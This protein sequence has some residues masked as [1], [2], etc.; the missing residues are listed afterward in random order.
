[1]E[2][3]EDRSMLSVFTVTNLND[4]GPDSLRQAVADAN[5]QAG[6]DEIRFAVA[7]T[8]ALS[9]GQITITDDLKIDGRSRITIS[10]NEAS[11]V[12]EILDADLTDADTVDVEIKRLSIIDGL[13]AG[14][15]FFESGGGGIRNIG[16]N[17]NLSH[18]TMRDNQAVASLASGGVA[19]AG[20]IDS[21]F[22]G[23][24]EIRHSRFIGNS[25][26][27]AL[28]TA[29]GAI[30]VEGKLT[31]SHSEFTDN[32]A[33]TLLGAGT[34]L[35]AFQGVAAGGAISIGSGSEA[36]I[37]YT[38]FS[39]NVARSGDGIV[40]PG[41]FFNGNAGDAVGGA[42]AVT[43]VSLVVPNAPSTLSVEHSLFRDNLAIGGDAVA[44]GEGGVADG[45]AVANLFFTSVSVEHS[46]FLGNEA[47][48]GA[49]GD[50][51]AGQ[52]GGIGGGALGGALSNAAGALAVE[53]SS[54]HGNVSRGGDGGN[55][56]ADA[57]G[58]QGQIGQGGAVS[59]H[60]H[61]LAPGVPPTTSI[62]G[63]L[64]TKNLAEGGSGG[65][66]SGS[67][68]G[69]TGGRGV[70][71]AIAGLGGPLTVEH[72]SI[73]FNTA[74]GGVG[75]TGGT[76]GVGGNGGN[77]LGGGLFSVFGGTISVTSSLVS[78]NRAIG[79]DG[80]AGASGG[81]GHGGGLWNGA[82]ATLSIARSLVFLNRA[83]GG[84]GGE[85]G[86]DAPGVGGG[87]Y[88]LGTIDVDAHSHIFANIADMF[89]DCFGC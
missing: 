54:F 24:L 70:G 44:S 36:S 31:V 80:A 63:S 43:P 10:G 82:D 38:Q 69:G 72:S 17:L 84:A 88:N 7:G 48:G 52:S 28:L 62:R 83:E 1:V 3:L 29:G 71:G 37:A 14:A 21:F 33:T 67:G 8:I 60:G 11:R 22:G 25:A 57:S 34:L 49:G 77:S 75:G 13:A 46:V 65:S 89:E 27:G 20:A 87:I 26:T 6:T 56:G 35:P 53:R 39:G 30:L 9:S 79:G 41:G 58:G 50:G 12:I 51:A 23:S 73:L 86:S 42:I 19:T 47:H 64:F 59:S 45:G 55:G 32:E 2:A 16:G 40:A 81:H 5:D 74:I 66:G 78:G 68:N 18:V 15:D 61:G 76:G 85:G 4:G